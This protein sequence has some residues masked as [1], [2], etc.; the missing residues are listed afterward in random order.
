MVKRLGRA[1]FESCLPKEQAWIQLF[2]VLCVQS[3][4]FF[5]VRQSGPSEAFSE[6]MNLTTFK[7]L[8]DL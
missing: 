4:R 5:Y 8:I 1:K 7:K 2:F 3:M 6:V